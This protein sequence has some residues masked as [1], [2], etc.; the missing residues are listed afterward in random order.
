MNETADRDVVSFKGTRSGILMSILENEPFAAAMD[1]LRDKIRG[2][3]NFF[4]GSPVSLDLGWRELDGEDL[5]EMLDF[6]EESGVRLLGII[7]SSLNTRRLCEDRNI[8]VIIGR[9]GLADHHGNPTRKK[10]SHPKQKTAVCKV[11]EKIQEIA[12]VPETP[13]TAYPTRE[14]N[15]PQETLMVKKTVRSGQTVEHPGNLVILGDV[16]PG[17]EVRAGGDLVIVGALRGVAHAGTVS[18]EDVVTIT[19]LKFKPTQIRIRDVIM[20]SFDARITRSRQPVI[21]TFK[22]GKIEI[23]IYQ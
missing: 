11:E 10:I 2:N 17:G 21:A 15:I 4:S 22:D 20:N 18:R 9:L 16:N 8:K 7:S 19:A 12:N 5:Q 23:S 13:G 3:R 14:M 1:S 6:F